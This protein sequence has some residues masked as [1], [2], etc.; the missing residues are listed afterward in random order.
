MTQSSKCTKYIYINDSKPR[1]QIKYYLV[2]IIMVNNLNKILKANPRCL[3]RY[4]IISE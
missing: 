4:L 1:C 3:T 2:V